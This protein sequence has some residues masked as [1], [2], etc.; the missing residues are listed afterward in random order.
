MKKFV[1]GKRSEMSFQ[2]GNRM[3][4]RLQ[5][6][7]Q[8]SVAGAK[9][10]KLSAKFYGSFELLEKNGTM[11]YWLRLPQTLKYTIHFMYLS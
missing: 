4:I 9:H 10:S 5:P 8:V 3:Y 7:K 11:A 1:D 2:V 6:Y